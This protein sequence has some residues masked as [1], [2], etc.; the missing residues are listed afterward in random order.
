MLYEPLDPSVTIT[1]LTPRPRNSSVTI[2]QSNEGSSTAET[3]RE[4]RM[5]ASDSLRMRWVMLG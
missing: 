4:V 3:E 1:V 5:A 2:R